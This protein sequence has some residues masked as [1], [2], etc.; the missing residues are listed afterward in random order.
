MKVPHLAE[1][2]IMQSIEDLWDENHREDCIRFFTGEDFRTCAS[3]A[4]MDTC[5]Q[6][7]ILTMLS[8]IIKD[9]KKPGK[10]KRKTTCGHFSTRYNFSRELVGI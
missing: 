1:A 6:I 4:G 10:D 8:R 5:E 2:V 7:K 9:M 3:I